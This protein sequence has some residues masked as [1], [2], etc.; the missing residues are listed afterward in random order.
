MIYISRCPYRISLLGGGSDLDWWNKKVS[1][2]LSFG[3]SIQEY[4]HI[5]ISKKPKSSLGILNYSSREIYDSLDLIVHPIIRSVFEK[6]NLDVP[7]ELTSFGSEVNGAGM[8]GSSSFTNALIASILKMQGKSRSNYEIAAYSCE[9]EIDVLNK[10]IGKQDQYL[11]ALG[12]INFLKFSKDGKVENIYDFNESQTNEF[13][14]Y[15]NSLVLVKTNINRKADKVLKKIMISQDDSSKQIMEI[16]DSAN[17]FLQQ[18]NLKGSIDFQLLD[19]LINKSWEKKRTLPSVLNTKIA[20]L[21]NFL[22]QQD[23]YMIK[24]LGAGGGGNF[25]CRP[26][27]DKDLFI[28]TVQSKGYLC[29]TIALDNIGLTSIDF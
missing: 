25:L 16:R 8:G 28:N 3:F 15:I 14:N 13:K 5:A 18:L 19:S 1:Y 9:I 6:F 11:T 20:D 7:V 26:K 12:G 22:R 21:E 27:K 29:S 2:G 17:I 10:P 24:L 4:T 23:L